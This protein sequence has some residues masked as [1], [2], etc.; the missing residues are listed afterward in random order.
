MLLL[1]EPGRG[2]AGVRLEDPDDLT[3]LSVRA[4]S[5]ARAAS[6]WAFNQA[7]VGS[8]TRDGLALVD[9][10]AL[11]RMASGRVADDWAQRFEDMLALARQKG[12][13][14]PDGRLFAH[15]DWTAGDAGELAS[16]ESERLRRVLGQFPTGVVIVAAEGEQGP[17]GLACQSFVSLSLDP[18]LVALA[19]ALTSRSWPRIAEVGAFCVS[20][21]TADQADICKKFAI[22]GG[23]KFA[24]LAWRPSPATGSPLIDGCLAWV[25]CRIEFVHEAGDHEIVV[26]RILDLDVDEGRPLVF[27]ASQYA[28]LA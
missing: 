15:T 25:D 11:R 4:R 10:D 14:A 28:R 24:E 23:D 1:I 7:G 12:W 13:T 26:G 19:P 16:I 22:S 2:P 18:P 27:Y 6:V 8:M 21:L 9:P 20:V 3:R 17:V 5:A